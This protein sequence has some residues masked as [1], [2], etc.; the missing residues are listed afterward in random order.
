MTC[1]EDECERSG[2]YSNSASNA[3]DSLC[4]GALRHRQ[5]IF[6]WKHRALELISYVKN[7]RNRRS[8]LVP[9]RG[10]T[11]AEVLITLGIIGV[12]AALAIPTLISNNNKRVVETRLAKF[13]STIN[14]AIEL[15]EVENGPKEKWEEMGHGPTENEDG[16]LDYSKPLAMPWIEKYLLPYM[17]TTKVSSQQSGQAKVIIEFP[18]GSLVLMSSNATEFYP[19]A[20]D[21]YNTGIVDNVDT[22]TTGSKHFTFFYSPQKCTES[23]K[24]HCKKGFEPYMVNWD[25]TESKL[26]NDGW[27]GC[28]KNASNAGAYCTQLIRMNG[29]KIPDDYPFKF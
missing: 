13:Y 9:L 26:K 10:F 5:Q 4:I 6:D 8:L 27:I 29:W 28:N 11:L 18:D 2:L 1:I 20:A 16:S 17:K 14:Q 12:V 19:R 7:L 25:G 22:S 15:S 3:V 21:Y 23:H 24:Y